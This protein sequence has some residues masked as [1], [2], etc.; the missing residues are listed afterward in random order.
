MTGLAMSATQSL[1]PRL[2][3]TLMSLGSKGWQTMRS[4]FFEARYIYL[5]AVVAAFGRVIS[6]VGISIMVGGN[7]KGLTRTMTTTIALETSK[8]EVATGIA[9]GVILV[10]VSFCVTA[11]L[12]LLQARSPSPSSH[13]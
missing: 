11:L 6:E 1:D 7:I 12:H 3:E 8:G 10:M 4:V 5:A 2:R 9:L 13:A